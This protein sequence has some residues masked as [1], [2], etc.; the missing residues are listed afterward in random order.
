[1]RRENLNGTIAAALLIGIVILGLAGGMIVLG[2][3]HLDP[4]NLAPQAVPAGPSVL[5]LVFG[6]L[7][8][9]YFGHTSAGNAARQ[10]LRRDPTGR[11][12][13]WGNLAAMSVAAVIYGLFVIAVNGSV[14]AA[15]L[16]SEQGT[17]VV[18]LAEVAGPAVNVMG[19][20]YVIL[21]LG[22]GSIFMALGL[23]LQ[24]RETLGKRVAALAPSIRFA[25]AAA[26]P[27]AVFVLAEIL[28]YLGSVSFTEPLSVLGVLVLPLLGG[29]FPMLIL[30]AARRRGERVPGWGVGWLGSRIV[31]VAI[32]A[33]YLGA[34]VAHALFIWSDPL[35]RMLA[36]STSAAIALLIFVAWRRGSFVPRT[37]VELRADDP[38]GAGAELS[39]VAAGR[40]ASDEHIAD[41][42]L[43]REITVD[44]PAARPDELYV[45]AHKPTRDGDT[46]P[47]PIQTEE[48]PPDQLVL[49]PAN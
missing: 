35:L 22:I 9:V 24:S 34:V 26:L 12:L 3:L 16:A 8:Y 40:R 18:P 42:A 10:V 6:V 32:L 19:T 37:V 49:R 39:V 14:P 44:L 47:L 25:M 15:R 1:M 17:A 45:W 7:L 31:V 20:I 4:R 28:L 36:A 11:T 21:S 5:A 27:V 41:L 30:A 33:L 23:Y 48:R 2:L 29:A 43:A 46:E 13:L 38:P